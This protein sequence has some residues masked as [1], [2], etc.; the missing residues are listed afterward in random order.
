M[1]QKKGR[2]KFIFLCVAPA[3]ILFAIFMIIPTINVFRMSVYKWSGFSASKEF[4]GFDNF[5]I[6]FEDMVFI[7][8][9]QNTVL[10]LVV[11]T[12]ITMSLAL[13]FAAIMSREQVKGKDL[14]RV[15]FYIP[16]ILSVVIIAAIFSAIYDAKDG[17]LNGF[18]GMLRLDFLQNMW[19]GD[20]RIVIYSVAAAMIWQSVGY[21][22][23]MYMASMSSIPESFYE[24]SALEGTGKVRQFF[25]I[26]LPLI[27][28]NLR[29]TLTF[30]IISSINLSF[31]L[32]KAMTGG[33]P[34][35]STEVF[36]NYM[37]KQA[38]TNSSYGYGMAIGSIV[39]LFS[40]GLSLAVSRITKRET[41][42]Y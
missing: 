19:L 12:I 36:L 39:F 2:S 25:S 21:Y 4:V 22:M 34:D 18:L 26:T 31:T 13:L 15:V 5:R 1:N 23:V 14:Y 3:F 20:Q 24:A 11:V 9:F 32:I 42:Q 41:L 35:G 38:Y 7:K 10:L 6:L 28:Q 33:G 40:F 30:F 29:N 17:L 16:N 27:W 37:Y 8:S